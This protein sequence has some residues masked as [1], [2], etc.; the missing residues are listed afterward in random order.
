MNGEACHKDWCGKRFLRSAYA[1]NN[2]FR[3]SSKIVQDNGN[4]LKLISPLLQT[5]KKK[6]VFLQFG[7]HDIAKIRFLQN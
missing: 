1:A 4:T 2:Y 7:L 5:I 3:N 6:V